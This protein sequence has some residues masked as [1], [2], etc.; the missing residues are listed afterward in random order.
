MSQLRAGLAAVLQEAALADTVLS[1][2]GN[3]AG[4]DHVLGVLRTFRKWPV[5][6]RLLAGMGGYWKFDL[7]LSSPSQQLQYKLNLAEWADYS[8]CKEEIDA[9]VRALRETVRNYPDCAL[10]LARAE[11]DRPAQSPSRDHIAAL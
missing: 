9:F 10:S 2:L 5:R 8:P 3:P 11:A 6:K 7:E 4:A 1:Y